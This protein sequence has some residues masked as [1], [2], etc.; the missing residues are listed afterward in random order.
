MLADLYPGS[1]H[2]SALGL[3]G[4]PDQ[5]IWQTARDRGSTV[6]TKDDD[7][8]RLSVVYGLPPK[9]IWIGIGN[10]TTGDVAKLLRIRQSEIKDFPDH[11]EAGF[12]A[13]Y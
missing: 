2:V 4:A 13:L 3:L 5:A 7:F 12:L 9:V 11:P 8:H 10:C 6:V 1:V